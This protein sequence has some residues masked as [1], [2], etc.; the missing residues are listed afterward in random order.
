MFIIRCEL[1]KLLSNRL[2]LVALVAPMIV[3]SLLS[4]LLTQ[5]PSGASNV[6]SA[7]LKAL[8]LSQIF[9]VILGATITGQEYT[10]AALRTSLLAVPRR[11]YLFWGKTALVVI[12]VSISYFL[13]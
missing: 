3:V 4:W 9:A 12:A 11:A 8:Q 10:E 7:V 1:F 5:S 2:G 13:V 6:Q